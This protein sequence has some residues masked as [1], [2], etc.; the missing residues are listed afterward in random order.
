MH[1][2]HACEVHAVEDISVKNPKKVIGSNPALIGAEGSRA[3]QQLWFL[4]DLYPHA[5]WILFHKIANCSS[6]RMHIDE[7][8]LDSN[9]SA[10]LQ[11]D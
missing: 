8:F 11:P 4:H 2:H 1:L 3:A 5:C 9:A 7:N 6:V 10:R